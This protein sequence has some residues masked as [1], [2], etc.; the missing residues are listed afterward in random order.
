MC[1]VIRGVIAEK[2]I[3]K[4]FANL[5]E[6][7][8]QSSRGRSRVLSRVPLS[9]WGAGGLGGVGAAG[10]ITLNAYPTV[11]EFPEQFLKLVQMPLKHIMSRAK[12]QERE[13][14][15]GLAFKKVIESWSKL[16]KDI[17]NT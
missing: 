6:S 15:S 2:Q 11:D 12:K 1:G 14:I 13:L 7:C 17:N 4:A 16:R 3:K 10:G 8:G 5:P 9:M